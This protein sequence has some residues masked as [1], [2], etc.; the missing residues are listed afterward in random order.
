MEERRNRP[1][2]RFS[3]AGKAGVGVRTEKRANAADGE[4]PDIVGMAAVYYNA[5]DPEGTTYQL[6]DN[7]F[8]RIMPG[9]FDAA[10]TRDDVRAL[11][12]HDP[13]LLLGRSTA[14][15]L[16]LELRKDGLSYR[17]T[18]PDTTAGR[19]TV[20]SL[21]RGDISGSSFAFLP[22]EGGVKWTKEEREVNGVKITLYFRDI[23]DVELFDVGPV[24]YPAYSGTSSGARSRPGLLLLDQRSDGSAEL[25]TIRRSLEAFQEA[26]LQPVIESEQRAR[27]LRLLELS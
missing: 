26:E 17:I 23:T 15:T 27:R 8:E 10:V 14:G 19:D 7:V 24:T 22:T 11:Q 13:R 4:L 9:A 2:L 1:D 3:P 18:P 21:N 6:Y 25:A 16:S 20:T 12:N 5:D